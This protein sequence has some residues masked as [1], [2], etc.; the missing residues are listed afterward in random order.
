MGYH[1]TSKIQAVSIPYINKV[2]TKNVVAQAPTGTGKT[3][4][5]ALGSLAKVEENEAAVQVIVLSPTRELSRQTYQVYQSL[6]KYTK[7]KLCLGLPGNNIRSEDLGHVLIGLPLTILKLTT[8]YK[9]E[10]PKVKVLVLD[11]ADDL[12]AMKGLGHVEN[13]IRL[14]K[15]INPL[16]QVLLFSATYSDKIKE[17]VFKVVK[18]PHQILMNPTKLS[19]KGVKQVYIKCEAR[20]KPAKIH[21]LFEKLTEIT[22]SI[23]FVN[24]RKFADALKMYLQQHGHDGVDLLMGGTMEHKERDIVF[25]RFKQMKT[26]ILI[27]TDLLVRGI[28]NRKVTLVI[29]VDIPCD[30]YNEFEPDY[31]NYLRRVGRTGRFYD[32]GVVVNM[33]ETYLDMKLL[34]KIEGFYQSTIS[35]LLDL[36]ELQDELSKVR[37]DYYG[38]G[39]G[40]FG[41]GD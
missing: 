15:N 19:L 17:Q 8:K 28:D 10:F 40:G 23:V 37:G 22:Q 13:I 24:T 20:E 29:N 27:T 25:D 7:I 38:I 34:K 21:E 35:E 39:E 2:P 4:A 9:K 5:F 30:P 33:V 36:D 6:I 31:E 1:R 41:G 3:F 32:E 14:Y 16:V 11:E 12:L 18:D 26:R